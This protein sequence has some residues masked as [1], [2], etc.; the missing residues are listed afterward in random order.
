MKTVCSSYVHTGD[1]NDADRMKTLREQKD[2]YT[3]I[4]QL[5]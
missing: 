1:A 5:F 2:R 3:K 4:A